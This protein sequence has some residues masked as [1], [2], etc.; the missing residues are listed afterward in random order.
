VVPSM[1]LDL[2][3]PSIGFIRGS[4]ISTFIAWYV[5][6]RVFFLTSFPWP[7]RLK[8][9]LLR[10]FGATVG[11]GLVI[12]PRVNIHYP[13]KICLGDHVWL[14]EEVVLLSFD[15]I[16]IGD[17]SCI[18]QRSYICAGNHDY[19][20]IRFS[21]R[22]SPVFIGSSVWVGSCCFVGPG[23]RVNDASVISAGS[24]VSGEVPPGCVFAGNPASYKRPRF[25][26][27]D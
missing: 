12:K 25:S 18:S 23:S 5:V 20:D 24:V 16:M 7:Y 19:R 13:W 22:N 1:R 8:S 9:W 17:N 3:D 27:L 14:G 6:K 10:S 26:G 21:Y 11:R 4:S 15:D 2:F